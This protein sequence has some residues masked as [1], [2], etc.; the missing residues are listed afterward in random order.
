MQDLTTLRSEYLQAGKIPDGVRPIVAHAWERSR[1]YGV[2]PEVVKPQAEDPAGLA[3]ARAENPI[4]LAAAEPLFTFAQRKLGKGHY[5]I[6]L[7]DRYGRILRL[8]TDPTTAQVPGLRE[9]NTVEGASWRESD[10]GSNGIGTCLAARQPVVLIGPEHFCGQYL[11]WTCIGIP[12]RL[13]DGE[14]TGAL[15]ISVPNP[16]VQ[17]ANWGWVAT[18]AR[19]LEGCLRGET[20]ELVSNSASAWDEGLTSIVGVIE[21]LITQLDLPATHLRFVRDVRNAAITAM[22]ERALTEQR[23]GES[24]AR[25]RLLAETMPQ[26]VW[27]ADANGVPDY[28]NARASQY[29]GL[30]HN[31]DGTWGWTPL[32]FLDDLEPTVLAWQSALAHGKVYEVEHRVQMHDGTYRWHLSRAMPFRDADGNVVK[33]FGTATEIHDQKRAQEL[34]EQTVAERTAELRDTVDELEHFSYTITHDMRAPLRAMQLF[35]QILKEEYG[36]RLDDTGRDYLRR[37]TEAAARMDTLV[38]DALDYSKAVRTQLPLEPIDAGAI[39]KSIVESYPQFQPPHAE[40][41]IVGDFPLVRANAAGLIQCLSNLL[42]NAVKFVENGTL[43]QVKV[44]AEERGSEIRFWVEDNGIGISREQ[45]ERVF[46]MFQ[47]LSKKYQ[48]TGVGLALV[49]KVAERMHGKVGF[50]SEPGQGSRFWLDFARAGR[51]DQA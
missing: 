22:N 19:Y 17:I 14:I 26:L 39:A 24:E 40:I 1:A 43:P 7:S 20:V 23:L 51:V 13:T 21:L 45:Q 49:R 31:P 34:L 35:G 5:V 18:A 50:E 10:I 29:K 41:R 2:D 47:R 4:L 28:Y 37:I 6:A 8:I 25:F 38:L 30:E 3:A 32:L 48:G 11:N 16:D 42:G 15:N 36:A 33:W 44:W 12:L 27:T 46:V 9:F